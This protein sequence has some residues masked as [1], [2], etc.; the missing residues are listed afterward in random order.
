[1][2]QLSPS[3]PGQRSSGRKSSF[4]TLFWQL[5]PAL[6]LVTLLFG[7]GLF[8]G[9]L[10][11][12]GYLPSIGIDQLSAQHFHNVFIDLDFIPSLKLTLYIS[13]TST[14]IAALLSLFLSLSIL[15]WS[16]RSK[17]VNFFLQI[18]LTVPHL[19]VT[20]SVL[21]L[22]SPAGFFSRI[23]GALSIIDSP[24]VFPLLVND[25]WCI[26]I[27]VTYVWKEVPFISFMLLSVLKNIGPELL[28]VGA[29]LKATRIQKFLF[30]ILPL[31]TP[32]LGSACLIVFAYT[33]GSFEVPYLLGQTYPMTLSVWAYKSFSDIDLLAR[34]EG[35]AIGLLIA[36]FIISFIVLSHLLLHFARKNRR[37]S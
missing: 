34:P 25:S 32:S 11:A 29:T 21:L 31:I 26:G 2:N 28:E 7:G 23:L 30:I 13:V 24:S 8:L 4:G 6:I 27:L 10:Q 3:T 20:V 22:L 15:R 33:F 1:M 5:G 9:I 19:V 17:L 12:L 37:Y 35:I 36:L 14:V 18:P 16:P